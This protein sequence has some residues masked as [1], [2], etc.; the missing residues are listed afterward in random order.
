MTKSKDHPP[1]KHGKKGVLLVNLGTPDSLKLWDIRK[2]LAE[3]L[4]DKRVIEV[5][6]VIWQPILQGIILNTRPFKTRRA[7]AKIWRQETDESPL[8]Y[9]TRRQAELLNNQIDDDDILVTY[10]M[11]YG[12]PSIK[13]MLTHLQK[14]GCESIVVLPLYPQ[15]CAA[16]TA[17]VCD[18]V[19]RVLMKMRW[20]PQVQIVPR[21]YDHPAYIKAIVNQLERDLERLEFKPQ[22]VVLSYHGV[23]KTYLQKGDPYH[24]QCH[25]TTR[26]IKEQWPYKDI[27]IETTFQSRFGPSEWLQ[28][29]TDKTLEALPS[30]GVTRI[31]MAT[32]GFSSDCVETLEEI[33]IEGQATFK[34]ASG[35]DFHMVS[36][37][38]DS[39]AHI[40]M[41]HTLIKPYLK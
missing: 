37:L 21:Y 32:P 13:K 5:P 20:Q 28:P 26:L 15:Y 3:F 34:E 16:T 40:R 8:R 31:M 23:P 9:Y 12:S 27:P 11:R 19:F 22:Q 14:A 18:E 17:T 6:S 30:M 1:V 10:A 7:Y 25:V 4:S 29:Y 38:N 39:P 2:Y 24:C 35:S 41:I 33:A 36:C